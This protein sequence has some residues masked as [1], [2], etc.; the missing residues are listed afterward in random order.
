MTGT[1]DTKSKGLPAG[2]TGWLVSIL[3]PVMIGIIPDNSLFTKQLKLFFID[4]IDENRL[5]TSYKPL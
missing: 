5:I 4:F 1:K 3:I 2:L